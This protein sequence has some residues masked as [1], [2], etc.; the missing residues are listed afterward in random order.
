MEE[1]SITVGKSIKHRTLLVVHFIKS[2]Y[3]NEEIIRII[4]GKKS[5]RERKLF[6]EL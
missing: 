3:E 2:N 6:C 5:Y 4:S 1:R